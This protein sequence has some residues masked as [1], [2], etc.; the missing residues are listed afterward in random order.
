MINLTIQ[1]TTN[2]TIFTAI[3]GATA[4]IAS[5]YKAILPALPRPNPFK[6]APIALTATAAIAIT[7]AFFATNLIIAAI[8]ALA[9]EPQ[10]PLITRNFLSGVIVIGAAAALGVNP[11]SALALIVSTIVINSL[12]DQHVLQL[13]EAWGF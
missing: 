13:S 12:L 11:L 4:Y 6:V 10:M 1:T 3:G 8:Y 2:A 5:S 7:G 9:K